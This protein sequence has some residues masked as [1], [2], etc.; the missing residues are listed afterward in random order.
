MECFF[1]LGSTRTVVSSKALARG[2][3]LHNV[4]VLL[5]GHIHQVLQFVCGFNPRVMS[6]SGLI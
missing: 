4:T 2:A 1:P 3:P 6:P 5:S